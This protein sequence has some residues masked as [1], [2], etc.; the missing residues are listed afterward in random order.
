VTA[1]LSLYTATLGLVIGNFAIALAMLVLPLYRHGNPAL[2]WWA[3]AFAL[4]GLHTACTLPGNWLGGLP[5][6]LA[7]HD[8]FLALSGAA[9]LCG[10]LTATGRRIPFGWLGAVVALSLLA[11]ALL[12]SL[13]MP[14]VRVQQIQ[15]FAA[16]ALLIGAVW[17]LVRIGK[18]VPNIPMLPAVVGLIPLAFAK[19]FQ[20]LA[21]SGALELFSVM[22]MLPLNM[23]AA[24]CLIVLVQRSAQLELSAARDRLAASERELRLSEERF[25]DIAETSSDWI[26]ETDADLRF[27]MLAG[28]YEKSSGYRREDIIGKRRDEHSGIA[29][30]DPNIAEHMKVLEERKPFRDFVYSSSDKTGRTR[31]TRVTGHPIFDEGGAFIGYRGTASDVTPH[32]EA[33]LAAEQARIQLSEAIE[34]LQTGFALFDRD[35]RLV[36]CNGQYKSFYYPN[37][38]DRLKPGTEFRDII[39]ACTEMEVVENA[40]DDPDA[41]LAERMTRHANPGEPFEQRLRDGRI[42]ST[43]EYRTREGGTVSVHTDV[44]E[45]RR[46]KDRLVE[47]IEG[48]PAAVL[49]C[50]A[51]DRIVICNKRYREDVAKGCA[52]AVE[53][54]TPYREMVETI[55]QYDRATPLDEE[56][57]A[58]IERRVD[59]HRN[60]QGPFFGDLPG[61][62]QVQVEE[63]RTQDGGT[64]SVY[65]DI[66]ALKNREA[67]LDQ[68]RA[69]LQL[70]LDNVDQGISMID[71]DLNVAAFNDQAMDLLDFPN[72]LRKPGAKFEEF[73]RYNTERGEYGD[74]DVEQLV[75]ERVELASKFE[76]HRFERARPDGRV[77]EVS[78][79]PLP[80]KGGIVTT[81]TDITERK[82]AEEALR[83]SEER[84]ALAMDGASEGLWDWDIVTGEVYLSRQ[85]KQI[86]D[87]EANDI[88][89]GDEAWQ[90]RMHPDDIPGQREQM[91][92]HLKGEAAQ[93]ECEYRLRDAD[94]NYRWFS[95]RALALRDEDGRAYRMAGSI[96]EITERKRAEQ[97]LNEAKEAAEAA[98]RTKSQFLANMSHE[99]RTPLNAIIGFSE[100]MQNEV[101]GPIG[102][103]HYG[104]YARDIFDSGSHLLNLINDILD[105]SKFEAGKIE[106][107]EMNCDV[108]L[109]AC[110][111][112]R[113]VSERARAGEVS[114]T[115]DAPP[116]LPWLRADELR[117]KQILLNLLSN[118][119][120][121]T[122]PEGEIT[123][124]LASND[125]AGFTV[126]VRDT[127]IGMS[128]DQLPKAMEAF[129][130]IDNQ[131]SRKYDG[132]GLGLPLTK[133]LVELHGGTLDIQSETGVGTTVQLT[134]PGDRIINMRQAG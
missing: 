108:R 130:Q 91:I 15:S 123:I 102:S 90:S 69:T 89:T 96:G 17:A 74:G 83:K 45:E 27:T 94:G 52:E 134:F 21:L 61:D 121:F 99:L 22:S 28:Q 35:S 5:G 68:A 78:G 6:M 56:T 79:V 51:D 49:Y 12:P 31:H 24:F 82:L 71:G 73:V 4:D 81:Y 109:I 117:M 33:K 26:W 25:R 119:V 47:A 98:N 34:S 93:Y 54:G 100:M 8:V 103:R 129:V 3:A 29:A 77:L 85:I 87:V 23:F 75:R 120:K 128:Q 95:D 37:A 92:A 80:N 104:D 65:M 76:P 118:S 55:T 115:I 125:E 58:W 59:A 67:E 62:R 39:A 66:T 40:T 20:P 131:L 86:L 122:P 116:D 97:A 57:K 1:E 46:A 114:I 64:V 2:K 107:Q 110:S 105:V 50:D 113:L 38:G 88:E 101:F 32:V 48:V 16:A 9:I 7:P 132:T 112:I 127:G 41:W 133:S 36:L 70:V 30:N 111:A 63:H 106:L 84:Y 60:P 19:G 14:A 43:R 10:V 72:E 13:G 18:S 124:A 11:S 53:P 44:T 126:E 42:I